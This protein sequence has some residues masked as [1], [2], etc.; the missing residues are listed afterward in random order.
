MHRY[1]SS[2]RSSPLAVTLKNAA[3]FAKRLGISRVTD[4]TRL[5]RLGIPVFASVRPSAHQGSLCVNAGKGLT[6]DEARAGAYMEAIE[7]AMA[8]PGASPVKLVRAPVLDIL[9]GRHRT[10]AILDFCPTL[11]AEIRVDEPILCVQA[12]DVLENECLVP[13]ELV[14]HPFSSDEPRHAYFGSDTNGLASGNSVLEASLHGLLEV[15]ERDICSFQSICD[16]S[17]YVVLGSLPQTQRHVIELMQAAGFELIVRCMPNIYKLA[18]FMAV[19]WERGVHE[20]LLVNTGFGCHIDASIALTRA[21]TEAVQ[22]R[23]SI[24][25]GARDDLAERHRKFQDWH[26]ERRC[27]YARRLAARL[28]QKTPAISFNEV[29][30]RAAQCDSLDAAMTMLAHILK[31]QGFARIWKVIF[32]TQHDPVQVV[33]VLVPKLECFNE[34]NRRVGKRLRAYARAA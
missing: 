27:E 13:A 23:L 4:I 14:F 19:L 17:R 33:R 5:D 9:D 34:V 11:G 18:Y 2:Y 8:E 20:P 26:A 28:A 22:S 21:I 3:R 32:T 7:F 10:D 24:I 25:H 16:T 29:P 31:S 30:N 1:A 12:T 6:E 15:I